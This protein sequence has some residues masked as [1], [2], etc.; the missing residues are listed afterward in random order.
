VKDE[1]SSQINVSYSSLPV[2][3]GILKT[4]DILTASRDTN[5]DSEQM[6][7]K[8]EGYAHRIN[9]GSIDNGYVKRGV[10]QSLGHDARFE[11]AI[12]TQ[13]SYH[14]HTSKTTS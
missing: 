2:A 6:H 7:M 1:D 13:S 4:D 8:K 3:L 5:S 10:V 12:M 9:L 11:S 14:L